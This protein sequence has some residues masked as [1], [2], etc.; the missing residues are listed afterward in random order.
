[1]APPPVELTAKEPPAL[2]KLPIGIQDFP[3]L[4]RGGYLY[5]DKT[6]QLHKLVTEGSIYFLSRPRR[7]GKSLLLSTLGAYFEG[8][9]ELFSGLAIEQLEKDWTK[10]P[11]LR[12]DLN[13][14]AYC[15]PDSLR[16][17]L[18][19]HLRRWEEEYGAGFPD[20]PLPLRFLGVIRRAQAKTGQG[21]VVLVD[22]Y[23]SPLLN[24]I[25]HPELLSSYKGQ[26]K[27]FYGALKSADAWLRLVLLTGVSKFGQV[28]VF[29]GLNQ[30][31][32]LSLYEDYAT[33]C[34]ITQ[35][36][37]ESNFDPEL[38][39]LAD[40]RGLSR[41]ECLE[42]MRRTYNGYKFHPDAESVYNPFSTLNAL[43]RREFGDFWF[44]SGTP[45]FLVEL[46]KKTGADLREIDGVEL[47]AQDFADY[48]ADPDYPLPV[49]YQSGYLT[50]Q[51]YNP[52]TQLYTLGYPNE[53]VRRGFLQF[54]L[55]YFA[56]VKQGTG[57]FNIS[58]FA[59][60]LGAGDVEAFLQ[61]LRSFFENIP[62]DL[63]DQSERHYQVVFYLV[64]TLL[65]QFVQAEVKS[66]KGRADAVVWTEERIFVFE[67]KLNGTAEEALK[68]IDEKGYAVPFTADGRP[69]V[70]VGVEFDR[71]TRNLGRWLVA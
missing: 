23:D 20:E 36:E 33:L 64:F 9:R 38:T 71:A 13:A 49:I 16:A 51:S 41:A 55:P 25:G 1:M 66:S 40:R 61:R 58:R 12:L 22:E 18:E 45:T 70:R 21:V 7:F 24:A 57:S 14:A 17:I 50:I 4:R 59:T 2:R 69:V 27:A 56:N 15:T 67:F 60:E 30:P 62:Y 44:Q 42:R 8:R 65:G 52:K 26:L 3:R 28:S 54:V 39:A 63:N 29:S 37:L 35:S 31:S 47:G 32:D 46:L 53:E 6:D 10:H 48:R 68:Q 11:V 5:V 19:S 43:G 34:G